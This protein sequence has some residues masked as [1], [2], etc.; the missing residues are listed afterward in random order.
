MNI[1]AVDETNRLFHIRNAVPEE[2]ATELAHLDW[3]AIAWQRQPYQE[4]WK[5]RMLDKDHPS[6]AKLNPLI[7]KS[8]FKLNRACGV[9]F[10]F[11]STTWWLDEPDFTVSIHTDGR[12]AAA[13]QLFWVMPSEEFGTTFYNSK[14][15]ADIRFQPKSV[16]NSG[17]IMLN[18]PDKD[19]IQPLQW[20]G[21]LNPVPADTIRVT[22]YTSF[23]T[24]ENK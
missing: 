15:S 6:L 16:P 5:R 4:S 23:V 13:I 22:S 1:T 19:G 8:I 11:A 12:L 9:K 18:L 10:M 7:E 20:H 14:D 21:M 17:Y 3:N 24:Y 2:Y